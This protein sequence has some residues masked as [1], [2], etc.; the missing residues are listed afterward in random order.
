LRARVAEVPLLSLYRDMGLYELA[1]FEADEAGGI[2]LLGRSADPELVEAAR[3]RIL[4][5]RRAELAR[6]DR[7]DG[8]PRLRP[9]RDEEEE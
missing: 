9:V 7:G 6:L 8:A 1:L 5:E 4:A 2:R 3:A